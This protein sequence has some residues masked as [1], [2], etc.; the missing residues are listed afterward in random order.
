M[1]ERSNHFS[2]FFLFLYIFHS[3]SEELLTLSRMLNYSLSSVHN[4]FPVNPT[5]SRSNLMGG[6]IEVSSLWKLERA[7]K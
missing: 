1:V 7:S 2:M 4:L 5:S 6:L 3:S